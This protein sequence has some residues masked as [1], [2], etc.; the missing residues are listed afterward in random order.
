MLIFWGELT[1]K[2]KFMA[3]NNIRFKVFSLIILAN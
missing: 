1:V 3:F 2:Y